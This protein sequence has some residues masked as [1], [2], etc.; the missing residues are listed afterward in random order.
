MMAH[1]RICHYQRGGPTGYPCRSRHRWTLRLGGPSLRAAHPARRAHQ[2][3][4]GAHPRAASHWLPH[5]HPIQHCALGRC[6]T[7]WPASP[8]VGAL[9]L[10]GTCT[11]TSFLSSPEISACLES[12]MC[13]IKT[14]S[15]LALLHWS[16]DQRARHICKIPRV[17]C[18][19]LMRFSFTRHLRQVKSELASAM[20]SLP[21]LPAS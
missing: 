7:G 13:T 16:S 8:Q 15:F 12:G 2:R 19:H 9:Q 11:I 6:L 20:Y 10:T 5:A 21:Y 3:T 4:L 18:A 17:H 1:L 14:S